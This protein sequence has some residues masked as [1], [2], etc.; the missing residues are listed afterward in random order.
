MG[1]T[2]VDPRG[3]VYSLGAVAFFM[4][5]GRP[6]FQG[7]NLGEVLSAHRSDLPPFLSDHQADIPPDLAEVVARC[8]A[9]ERGER[10]Q[11]VIDLDKAIGKCA[12]SSEW[13]AESAERWWAGSKSGANAKAQ[14]IHPSGPP[15]PSPEIRQDS[16][17]ISGSRTRTAC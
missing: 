6:P 13:S 4:L 14:H 8:L 10:F 17:S 2:A 3:D 15:G 9:K 16:A 11:S 7:K 1:D 12:C 5:T